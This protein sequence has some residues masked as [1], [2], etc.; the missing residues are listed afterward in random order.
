MGYKQK[1][2]RR[3]YSEYY[4]WARKQLKK[5]GKIIQKKI[6]P[7]NGREKFYYATY[8]LILDVFKKEKNNHLIKYALVYSWMPRIP[9]LEKRVKDFNEK[10]QKILDAID[11]IR[12]KLEMHKKEFEEAFKKLKRLLNGSD[13]AASKFLHFQDPTAFPM[14]DTKMK[15]WLKGKGSKTYWEFVTE[16]RAAIKETNFDMKRSEWSSMRVLEQLVWRSR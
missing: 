3:K 10:C 1:R 6:R 9:I 2:N 13:I 12:D 5:D 4:K 7:K 11:K 8:P 16:S 15:K 14:W